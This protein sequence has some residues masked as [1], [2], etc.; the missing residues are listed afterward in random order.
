MDGKCEIVSTPVW[1]QVPS[2]SNISGGRSSKITIINCICAILKLKNGQTRGWHGD[3][4][5][6]TYA[7]YGYI[8]EKWIKHSKVAPRSVLLKL[9]YGNSKKPQLASSCFHV[10]GLI[11]D[12]HLSLSTTELIIRIK[13]LSK[14]FGLKWNLIYGFKVSPFPIIMY[15]KQF[16][17]QP[18]SCDARGSLQYPVWPL[19]LNRFTS[20]PCTWSATCATEGVL[21][22]DC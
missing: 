6:L 11:D 8:K 18:A 22:Y 13:L 9:L 17:R 15:R 12:A 7:H 20:Q 3:N 4:F 21:L 16:L 1:N 2:V 10:F 14:R 5:N 19:R